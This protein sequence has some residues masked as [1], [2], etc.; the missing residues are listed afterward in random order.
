MV[1]DRLEKYRQD[2]RIR[3]ADSQAVE[4]EPYA[5]FQVATT[6]QRRFNVRP[7]GKAERVFSYGY[8]IDI[9]HAGGAIVG[10]SFSAPNLS[11][12]IDGANLETLVDGLREERVTHITEHLPAWHKPCGEEEPYIKSLRIYEAGKPHD[13]EPAPEHDVKRRH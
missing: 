9:R 10:L 12:E 13:D 11:I 3:V 4:G 5:A 8:L 6:S 1:F 7:V 2:T